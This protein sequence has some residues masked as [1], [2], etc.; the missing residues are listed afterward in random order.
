MNTAAAQAAIDKEWDKLT[1]PPVR[2]FMNIK[3]KSEVVLLAKKDG[4][5][6]HSASLT[7]F[8]HLKHSELRRRWIQS[9]IH[10]ASASQVWVRPPPSRRPKHWNSIENQWFSLSETYTVT[11]WKDCCGKESS[12][13]HVSNKI[14]SVYQR[15]K[16]LYV[17][18]KLSVQVADIKIWLER[19]NMWD[20]CGEF[21]GKT[22]IW[23]IRPIC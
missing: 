19:K 23:Q 5:L 12:K 9:S 21:C 14:G 13:K 17:F 15:E 10:G 7:D 6:F 18:R 1:H 20:L 22:S 3:P 16:C 8:C 4:R 11:H 2:N